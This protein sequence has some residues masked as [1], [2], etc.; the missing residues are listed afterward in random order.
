MGS[1]LD[2]GLRIAAIYS[3]KSTPCLTAPAQAVPRGRAEEVAMIKQATLTTMGAA[4]LSLLVLLAETGTPPPANAAPPNDNLAS[5]R[6]IALQPYTDLLDTTGATT[7]AGE[8][9]GYSGCQ[10]QFSGGTSTGATAWYRYTAT[11]NGTL[12]VDTIGPPPFDAVLGVYSGPATPPT[13][14]ALTYIACGDEEFNSGNAAVS[15]AVTNGTTYYFQ[16]GGYL[17]ASGVNAILN[18]GAA[19]AT[20]GQAFTVNSTGDAGDPLPGDGFCQTAVPGV[21]TLRAAIDEAN[22][23]AGPNFIRFGIGA[24]AATITMSG[25][26]PIVEPVNIDARTQ[27]GF[28]GS[29]L[30]QLSGPFIGFEVSGGSTTMRGL[31]I[32]GA[33]IAILVESSDNNVIQGNWLGTNARGTGP[34]P[35]YQGV[36]MNSGSD[37]NTVGG[38]TA[39]A[40]NVL[41]GNT[42]AGVSIFDHGFGGSPSNNTV[43]GN[44]I[45]LDKDGFNAVPNDTGVFFE[46][47]PPGTGGV[48]NQIG[49]PGAGNVISGNEWGVLAVGSPAY[50]RIRSNWIGLDATGTLDRGN[51]RTGVTFYESATLNWI[52][53]V[54]TAEG[55]V[56]SG[57]DLVGVELTAGAHA[58]NLGHNRI[59]VAADG[60]T[61][62]GNDLGVLIESN[63]NTMTDNVVANS[64]LEGVFVSGSASGNTIQSGSFYGNGRMAIDLYPPLGVT[65]NDLGDL[66]G[67]PNNLQNFPVLSSAGTAGTVT[68]VTG[69]LNTTANTNVAILFYSNAMCDG[70]HGEGRTHVGTLFGMTDGAGNL[71]F[72]VTMGQT[73]PVGEV[74]TAITVNV[75]TNDTSEFSACRVVTTD[76]DGDGVDDVAEGQC[77][78]AVD[79]DGDGFVNDACPQV[80]GTSEA[81]SQCNNATDDDGDAWINDGCPGHSETNACG[82]NSLGPSRPERIDGMF[83]GVSD[84]GDALVDEALP[85]GAE[86]YDCDGDGFTGAAETGTPLCGNGKND[87]GVSPMSD[88]GV[89]DDGCPGGPAQVGTFSEAQFK[90]GTLDQDPCG[91]NGWPLELFTGA[92]SMN[93]ITLQDLTSFLGGPRRFGTSPGHPDFSSRWD[94]LPGGAPNWINLQD[95]T[96]MIA[97]ASSTGKPPMLGG[98]R[99]FGSPGPVCPWP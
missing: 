67:G 15:F 69:N 19:P 6:D 31:V 17:G 30:I 4:L 9:T 36:S 48:N 94:L 44:Y 72:T 1:L 14:G 56:I 49:L 60:V 58:N 93:Q 73:V 28:S 95:F 37:S 99:A 80:G 59:G 25:L 35:N 3:Q 12:L 85:A 13:Y 52:G 91:S 16:L 2:A 71:P 23:L 79:D 74:M 86:A 89:L 82:S 11:A 68:A 24:G 78:N 53:G 98:A 33:T 87:D 50:N 40:R 66:D 63:A 70:T 42:N 64:A 7:E 46:V 51:T 88:D 5:A 90:I 21:C 41:S 92:G 97:A 55:N 10:G 84:D 32:N 54:T 29:P 47:Q 20:V 34:A 38:T 76:S 45:G 26:V 8:T 61:P 62:M 27:P 22:N 43:I 83:A 65:P 96:A 18:L 77:G 39:A 81:G 75:D 57:N